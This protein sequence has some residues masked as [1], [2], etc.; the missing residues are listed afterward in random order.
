M[1]VLK[2]LFSRNRRFKRLKRETEA[3]RLVTILQ[4][5][6]F[7]TFIDVG[8]NTGQTWELLRK[9]GYRGK[10]ISIEPLSECHDLL[11]KKS[12]GDPDWIIAP[13]C[14]LSDKEGEIEILV[15]EGSSLSSVREP[16]GT[17]SG[18]L[19]KVRAESKEKVP[20]HRLDKLLREEVEASGR[21]FLKID[22]QGHDMEVLR[23]AEGVIDRIDG[24]KIEMSLLP[25][26]EGETL[27]LDILKYLDS[28]GF[29]PRLLVD[30]G[31]SKKLGRQ[32]QID[33]T[34]VRDRKPDA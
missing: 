25:L 6:S 30:V 16:T 22:A 14:A 10:I 32:L 27:Y 12:Q 9:F 3:V 18:A 34:F 4:S 31:Y 8:A 5:E 7:S 2:K 24:V 19:P 11:T 20:L 26:Y 29:S 21:V 17:M 23:G 28:K 15:S 1:S 13:R 33:G